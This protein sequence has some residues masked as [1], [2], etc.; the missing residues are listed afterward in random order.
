M[1]ARNRK[2]HKPGP[3]LSI[4]DAVEAAKLE[5]DLDEVRRCSEDLRCVGDDLDNRALVTGS[6]A[7]GEQAI[8]RLAQLG[9]KPREYVPP[10]PPEVAS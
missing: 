1:T 3:Q 9:F 7:L 10:P 4:E 8:E 6:A 5:E 2:A